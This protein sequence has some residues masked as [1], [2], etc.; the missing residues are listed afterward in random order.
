MSKVL[1]YIL[2]IYFSLF[3]SSASYAGSTL[4]PGENAPPP[5]S[6]FVKKFFNIL[7]PNSCESLLRDSLAHQSAL[8]AQTY[9][10]KDVSELDG[11]FDRSY[12]LISL[13]LMMENSSDITI[14]QTSG[15]LVDV[16]GEDPYIALVIAADDFN[17]DFQLNQIIES[18]QFQSKFDF[19]FDI[20]DDELNIILKLVDDQGK[21]W[22]LRLNLVPLKP[23]GLQN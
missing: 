15:E 20:V 12:G 5:S 6:S 8:S 10:L 18:Q 9:E 13:S 2:V 17:S 21:P 4:F 14:F 11:L 1:A 22:P 3:L 7:E 19:S 23:L 16:D